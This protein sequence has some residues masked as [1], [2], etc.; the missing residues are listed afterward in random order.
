MRI[1]SA[2]YKVFLNGAVRRKLPILKMDKGFGC[3]TEE[4]MERTA[5]QI[6]SVWYC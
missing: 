3:I 2:L 5:K 6:E 4:D 1:V